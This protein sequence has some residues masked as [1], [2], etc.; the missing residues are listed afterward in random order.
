M[1]KLVRSNN[2]ELTRNGLQGINSLCT[3][4]LAVFSSYNCS[5]MVG[6]IIDFFCQIWPF[7]SLIFQAVSN[8]FPMKLVMSWFFFIPNENRLGEAKCEKGPKENLSRI[9]VGCAELNLQALIRM[10]T[11]APCE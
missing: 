4:C 3:C 1:T 7:S 5:F 10:M 11:T 2:W 9:S 6:I 8:H